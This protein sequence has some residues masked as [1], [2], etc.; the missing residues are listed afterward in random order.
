VLTKSTYPFH[1]RLPE[2]AL[3]SCSVALLSNELDHHGNDGFPNDY[4]EKIE[5][6][7]SAA[8]GV[9]KRWS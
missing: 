9:E 7:S 6:S 2:C 3:G 8:Q 1:R 4:R 5:L